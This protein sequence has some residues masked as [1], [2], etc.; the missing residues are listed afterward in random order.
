MIFRICILLREFLNWI[1][2]PKKGEFE[3]ASDYD[4]KGETRI[5]LIDKEHLRKPVS[6]TSL[7]N[8]GDDA[9]DANCQL[10]QFQEEY[11]HILR[12]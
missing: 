12:P 2:K 6:T 5:D 1:S 9:R 10:S 8:Q 11:A 7:P 4:D 3:Y